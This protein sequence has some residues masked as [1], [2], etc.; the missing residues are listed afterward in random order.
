MS[1][2][3]WPMWL[4]TWRKWLQRTSQSPKLPKILKV[5]KILKSYRKS[6]KLPKLVAKPSS[7]QRPTHWKPE[8]NILNEIEVITWRSCAI[9]S[10]T[11]NNA[12][13]SYSCKILCHCFLQNSSIRTILNRN[14]WL[15][16]EYKCIIIIFLVLGSPFH[17]NWRYYFWLKKIHV[18]VHRQMVN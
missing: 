12:G 5:A 11:G 3:N 10:H 7:K 16:G 9:T 2:E 14:F 13:K 4:K 15:L 18:T 1:I 17:S 8:V 6:Q